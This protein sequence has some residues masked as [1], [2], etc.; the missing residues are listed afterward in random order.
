[1]KENAPRGLKRASWLFALVAGIGTVVMQVPSELPFATLARPGRP[2][3]FMAIVGF[4]V[5]RI[6]IWVVK[7]FSTRDIQN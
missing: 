1:M 5:A 7:G 6:A 4:I 3:L 2:W